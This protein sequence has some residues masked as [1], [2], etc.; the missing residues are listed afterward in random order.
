MRKNRNLL[1]I[2]VIIAAVI[3]A[4]PLKPWQ[5]NEKPATEP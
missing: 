3:M 4:L 1:L 2:P 5:E